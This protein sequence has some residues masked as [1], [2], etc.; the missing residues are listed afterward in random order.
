[1]NSEDIEGIIAIIGE[2]K[3]EKLYQYLGSRKISFAALHKLLLR[4]QICEALKSN[5]ISF[6]A[7]AK[8]LGVSKMTLYRI[9]HCLIKR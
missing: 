7:L 5:K 4:K 8:K 3:A 6:S 9:Y 1:V 2:E